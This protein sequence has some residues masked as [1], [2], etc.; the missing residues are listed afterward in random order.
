[1]AFLWP[2]LVTG[3]AKELELVWEQEPVLVPVLVPVQVPEL[4]LV[5]VLSF[6]RSRPGAA[7]Q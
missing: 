7:R 5:S 3:L 2:A 6:W 4:V 1:M